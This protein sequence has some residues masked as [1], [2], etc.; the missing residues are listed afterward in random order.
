MVVKA[1]QR[2]EAQIKGRLRAG[3]DAF[4]GRDDAVSAYVA[5][6]LAAFTGFI[7]VLWDGKH[8]ME[9]DIAPFY[10][11]AE[12]L[13]PGRPNP[14]GGTRA[15]SNLASLFIG[16]MIAAIVCIRVFIPVVQG[17]IE[18]SNVSGT[19]ATILGLLPMF[20]ALLLLISLASPLM[21]SA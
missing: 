5:M 9:T 11:M 10:A 6:L 1:L 20:A 15:Q 3:E 8:P 4:R 19:E 17:A 13:R 18:D 7:E 16:V 12:N 21:R 14:A 2:F